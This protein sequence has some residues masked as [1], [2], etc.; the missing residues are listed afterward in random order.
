MVRDVV[1]QKKE[2]ESTKHPPRRQ[3]ST[4]AIQKYKVL[5]RS[6]GAPHHEPLPVGIPRFVDIDDDDE[7]G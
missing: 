1:K 7:D 3:E 2:T 6:T 4:V 5:S